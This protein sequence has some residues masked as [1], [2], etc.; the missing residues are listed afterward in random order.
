MSEYKVK[1]FNQYLIAHTMNCETYLMKITLSSSVSI[2][3]GKLA[4][5]SYLKIIEFTS[6]SLINKLFHVTIQFI[7]FSKSSCL[8]LFAI[9]LYKPHKY[10]SNKRKIRLAEILHGYLS[11]VSK[12]PHHFSK[13]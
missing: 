3:C 1:T 5:G 2:S 11:R 10:F 7:C 4:L 6:L 13:I 8:V 12:S 9:P